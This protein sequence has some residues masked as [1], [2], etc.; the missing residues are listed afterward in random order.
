MTPIVDLTGKHGL[1]VGIANDSSIAHGCARAFRHAGA[2]LD[3]TYLNAK[4]EPYVRPLAQALDVSIVLPCDVRE[5]GQFEAVFERM[6]KEWG[7]LDFLFHSIAFASREDLQTSLVNCSAEGF[8]M[9]MDVSCHSFIRMARLAAPLMTAGGSLQTVSFYGADRIVEN[10]NLIGPGKA[11]L[12]STV[13]TLATD[14]ASHCIY[15]HA[16]SA[17]PIKSGIDRFD[18]LLDR[19]RERTPAC[20]DRADAWPHSSPATP[21]HRSPGPSPM[22]IKAF[23]SSHDQRGAMTVIEKKAQSS[24]RGCHAARSPPT[25]CGSSLMR[26][27]TISAIFCARSQL[28]SR[29]RDWS[30]TSLKEKLIKIVAKVVHHG[31][32]VAFQ[33]AEVAIPRKNAQGDFAA[34]RETTAA[35]SACVRGVCP[36][37][38][39]NGQ[40]S[41]ST[42]VRAARTAGKRRHLA[43]VLRQGRNANTHP[44]SGVIWRIPSKSN[45]E[46]A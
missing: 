22:P 17:E 28:R 19:V 21:V 5:P 1:V 44:S 35:A 25:P 32:Y 4:A 33:M 20:E 29:S 26:S 39:E 2:D 27:P 24:G 7:R 37:V 16:L 42:T 38:R 18:E 40:I 10:Y 23:T 36:N 30:L 14:L 11:A 15:V 9:A 3:F 45:F 46:G 12:E 34:D 43:S 31:R 8:A 6:A 13:R 41:P